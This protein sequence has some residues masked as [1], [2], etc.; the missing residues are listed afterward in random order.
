MLSVYYG[1]IRASADALPVKSGFFD[2]ALALE[3]I[4][5]INKIGGRS[6]INEAK[7]VSSCAIM[8]TPNNPSPN[9]D[10]PKWVPETEMHL[11]N[12][13]EQDFQAEGFETRPIGESILALHFG[14]KKI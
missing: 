10:L 14:N 1:V 8:S 2:T 5:H 13:T 4:E 9:S 12:W 3:I 11:S 6:L 7:R